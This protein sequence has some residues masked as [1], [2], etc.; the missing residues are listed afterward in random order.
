MM[1]GTFISILTVIGLFFVSAVNAKE[2]KTHKIAVPQFHGTSVA[3][4]AKNNSRNTTV[5]ISGPKGYN[6][7]KFS[8]VG[9]PSIDLYRA[10][11]LADGLYNYEITTAVGKLVLI[12]DTMNNGR[13]EN[14]SHYARKGVT[15]SGHFRVVNGQIKRYKNIKEPSANRNY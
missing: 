1:K 8:E 14:D 11:K 5:T 6:V 15:Q 9:M 2:P 10:G 12:K 4:S 3:F 7:S 13:G